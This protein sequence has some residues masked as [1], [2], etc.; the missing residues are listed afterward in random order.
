M[1]T[2]RINLRE[3]RKLHPE[4]PEGCLRCR[5]FLNCK[6]YKIGARV[7]HTPN[8]I[9]LRRPIAEATGD[10]ENGHATKKVL[11]VA[12][13]P[14]IEEDKQGKILVGRSGKLLE[15]WVEGYLG[16]HIVYVTNAVKCYA[17][18][19]ALSKDGALPMAQIKACSSFLKEDIENIKPDA[20]VALGKD[21][22]LALN[23]LGVDYTRCHHPSYI[24][25]GGSD[26][27][28]KD[29]L[30]R[31]DAELKGELVKIPYSKDVVHGFT[32][33]L[34]F[35]WDY[36]TGELNTIGLAS[37]DACVGGEWAESWKKDLS[38]VLKDQDVVVY[39][40]DLAR[41]EVQKCLEIGITDINCKFM[42]SFILMRELLDHQEDFALKEYAYRHLLVE[43][44]TKNIPKGKTDKETKHLYAEFMKSYSPEVGRV[45]AA[46][47]WTSLYICKC[48]EEDWKEEYGG[49]KLGREADMDMILPTAVMMHK[50]IGLDLKKVEEHR[51]K[52]VKLVPQIKEELD[53]EYGIDVSKPVQ[54]LEVLRPHGA[55]DTTKETLQKIADTS[56][57]LKVTAFIEK[58]LEYR[59]VSKL[60]GTYLKPLPELVDKDG[61]IHSYIQIA[62]ANNGRPTSSSPNIANIPRRGYNMKDIFCSKFGD[63]GVLVTLDASESEFRCFAYLSQDEFLIDQ[64]KKGV[65][66]HTALAKMVGIERDAVKTLNFARLYGASPVK[67]K[68][69]LLD[70][71]LSGQALESA[72]KKYQEATKGFTRWQ[73]GIINTAYDRGYIL[74]PD[75][76]RGYRLSPNEIA[77]YPVS[78]FSSYLNKRRIRWVFDAFR[79]EG[80]VSHVWMDYYDGVEMDIYLPELEKVKE[81]LKDIPQVIE[82]VLDYGIELPIPL[83][84]KIHGRSWV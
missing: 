48:L 76:R 22:S 73:K 27:L 25:H 71:G 37:E 35:E 68:S 77:N 8:T 2:T 42:D 51:R 29:M 55:R 24:L 70:A 78:T 11:L 58:V 82:D 74:A 69:V 31:V 38:K 50:G 26:A 60:V 72:F 21:A 15:E 23:L 47:A 63:D 54:V 30:T 81:I 84:F 36:E 18:K 61:V 14:G 52:L 83:E 49:M 57:D 7:F 20:I 40:H 13:N 5:W 32:I 62:G 6:S 46:D 4:K 75:G 33:G 79:S 28:S 53:R 59:R 34:D 43:D 56:E 64:Y 3:L 65:G 16:D 17:P 10:F 67:L 19:E 39:G 45:C 80:L 44:Y 9:H 66:M 1:T 12:M 41:A